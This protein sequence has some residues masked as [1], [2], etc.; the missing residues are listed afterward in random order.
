MDRVDAQ[1]DRPTPDGGR[2]IVSTTKPDYGKGKGDILLTKTNAD[3][4]EEWF[5][6][7]GGRSYDRAG[8]VTV[9]PDGYLLIGSTSSFG[10]GNYDVYVIRTDRTGKELWSQTYGATG[11]EYG[12]TIEAQ[13]DGGF[14]LKGRKQVCSETA[15][16]RD[17]LLQVKIDGSGQRLW[18]KTSET[19]LGITF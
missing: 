12:L 1:P 14:L 11:N 3:G 5:K 6:T 4:N 10:Q 18:E 13:E 19:V 16:C 9:L 15:N 2:I 8:S 17:Y 7:F